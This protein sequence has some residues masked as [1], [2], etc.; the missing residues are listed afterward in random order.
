ML[1]G[2]NSY[3]PKTN[4]RRQRRSL[5]QPS[6]VGASL[7]ISHSQLSPGPVILRLVANLPVGLSYGE[8]PPCWQRNVANLR[9]CT[10]TGGHT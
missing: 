3:E 5:R 6:A 7:R 2:D 4:L 9:V 10:D 1:H 8:D